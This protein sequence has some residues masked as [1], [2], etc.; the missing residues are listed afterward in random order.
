MVA[1]SL[2]LCPFLVL[3]GSLS[4]TSFPFTFWTSLSVERANTT[5]VFVITMGIVGLVMS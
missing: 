2:S 4:E 5:V 3:V 1:A